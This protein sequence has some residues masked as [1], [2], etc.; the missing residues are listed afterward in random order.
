MIF[1]NYCRIIQTWR[2]GSSKMKFPRRGPPT[3]KVTLNS[4]RKRGPTHNSAGTGLNIGRPAD[5]EFTRLNIAREPLSADPA[6]FCGPTMSH[7]L[8]R[9]R[10]WPKS[11]STNGKK[12]SSSFGGNHQTTELCTGYGNQK[13][14]QANPPSPDTSVG[15]KVPLSAL[16]KP[17]TSS[18]LLPPISKNED[19]PSKELSQMFQ[20][21]A[22]NGFLTPESS[23]SKTP[24]SAIRSMKRVLSSQTSFTSSCSPTSPLSGRSSPVQ[25][26]LSTTSVVPEYQE[27]DGLLSS[28][29]LVA[30]ELAYWANQVRIAV[31]QWNQVATQ[32]DVDPK[33]WTQF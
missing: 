17:P 11:H 21:T 4:L 20:K 27:I 8:E 12:N 16:V 2:A 9:L 23:R 18:T 19:I 32:N 31:A 25:D 1:T 33:H 28:Q 10:S 6:V 5:P 15:R 7:Y 30:Q 13:A 24:V 3:Y 22:S 29:D 14:V 26:G